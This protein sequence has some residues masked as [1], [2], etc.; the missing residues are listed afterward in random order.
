M[1]SL[2]E[3]LVQFIEAKP[4]SEADLEKASH[5]VLDALA[6]TRAGQSTEPGT[7]PAARHFGSARSRTSSK[8]TTCTANRSRIR[9]AS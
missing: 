1:P 3:Q 4:I 8:P 9:G 7:M 5:Y 6:N 2:T